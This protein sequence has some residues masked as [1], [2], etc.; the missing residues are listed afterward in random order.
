VQRVFKKVLPMARVPPS[1]T[2]R[3]PG[4]ALQFSFYGTVHA[5][6]QNGIYR[7]GDVRRQTLTEIWE[8][9]A[10]REMGARLAVGD[11]PTGCEH[12]AI[13]HGLGHRLTTPAQAFDRF[14]DGAEWPRQ[15]EFTLSNRCNLEC[16]HCNG[17]NSSTIR[18]H[19]E[20][21]PPMEMPY[22]EAF[23]EQLPPFLDHV[24]VVA[25]LGGEPFLAPEARRVWDLLLA[26]DLHPEVQVTTNATIW[27]SKVERYVDDLRMHF[28][29]SI[30]GATA[31]TY[32]AIRGRARYDRVIAIRDLML[33]ASRRHGTYFQLNYCLLR[34]NWHELGRFLL[35]ADEL[36]VVANIIPVFNPADH[37]V[38]TLPPDELGPV[39]DQLHA[40][41]VGL[42]PRL[43]RNR[44]AWDTTV[45]MLQT[46][47]D[48][49]LARWDRA[50]EMR[51]LRAE[52]PE[53]GRAATASEVAV[54]V[55][56]RPRVVVAPSAAA[57]Q[58]A[59]AALRA[60]SGQPCIEV[61]STDG[62]V[63]AVQAPEWASALETAAW[64][65]L[66]L[67]EVTDVVANE[68]GP[69]EF[70]DPEELSPGLVQRAA[71]VASAA[72][73]IRLRMLFVEASGR[74]LVA[75]PD[76]IVA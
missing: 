3:A 2:C 17:D 44:G 53:M 12:C 34:A 41:G 13:E 60:W 46:E 37:S 31:E 50:A 54:G 56:D 47:L 21:R 48:Q 8:S 43:G 32:E 4:V 30:D 25:F 38:F 73:P 1:T 64:P 49:A 72:G 26:R 15:M 14:A 70:A 67:V 74:L 68:L 55:A 63:T 71:V 61:G 16:V 10:R 20:G 59:E 39:V 6:C 9:D 28:A 36:D 75:S 27:N 76:R 42:R 33:A 51:R 40:E 18:K 19:R 24:E 58:Q 45:G 57:V 5:C 7:I 29:V 35:Q 52:Q 69:I 11:Y 23:F 66:P 65:G 22:G 62:L